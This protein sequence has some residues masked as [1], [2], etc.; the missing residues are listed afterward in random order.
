M[1]RSAQQTVLPNQP[2]PFALGYRRQPAML[3]LSQMDDLERPYRSP[4]ELNCETDTAS[5]SLLGETCY[6]IAIVLWSIPLIISWLFF[7]FSFGNPE[8]LGFWAVTRS[9]PVNVSSQPASELWIYAL[10]IIFDM[11]FLAVMFVINRTNRFRWSVLVLIA[12]CVWF[13]WGIFVFLDG[14]HIA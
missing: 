7:V 2:F 5:R 8:N 13:T 1:N 4:R 11:S 12:L 14:I 3:G 6:W 9:G 10:P